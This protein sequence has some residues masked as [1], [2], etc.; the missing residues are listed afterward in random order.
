M[1]VECAQLVVLVRDA[2]GVKPEEASAKLGVSTR[3]IRKYVTRVNDMLQGVASIELVH[4]EGYHLHVEKPRELDAWL[5]SQDGERLGLACKTPQERVSYLLNV[6][7]LRTDWIKLAE[8]SQSLFVSKSALS[9]DLKK[10]ED[11]LRPYGLELEKRSHYGVRV[12]G[13]EMS[14][15]LCLANAAIKS[16]NSLGFADNAERLDT[17]I[18]KTLGGGLPQRR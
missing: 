3:T 17:G 8:L 16:V 13:P 6:L 18:L 14:R 9:G 2:E 15:R 1:T 10:V 5:A 4:G 12:T 11:Q 7:L